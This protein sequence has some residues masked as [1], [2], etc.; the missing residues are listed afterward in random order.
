MHSWLTWIVV[1]DVLDVLGWG[2]ALAVHADWVE[3]NCASQAILLSL[4][5]KR[6]R[7][8]ETVAYFREREGEGLDLLEQLF[9]RSRP[10]AAIQFWPER[11]GWIGDVPGSDMS[12][13]NIF[14]RGAKQYIV[15][16][17]SS[18]SICHRSTWTS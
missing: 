14:W 16:V 8:A 10:F 2:A 17:W 6:A 12:C 3:W 5:E 4:Q 9:E 7:E 11:I 1:F 15:L 13:S 18:S